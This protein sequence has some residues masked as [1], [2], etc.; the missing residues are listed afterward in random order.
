MN[1]EVARQ[2]PSYQILG[3]AAHPS[4]RDNLQ[5]F[6]RHNNEI[7]RLISDGKKVLATGKGYPK[8]A[9]RRFRRTG[10]GTYALYD[11]KRDVVVTL[12][13]EK[14]GAVLRFG[15]R[16]LRLGAQK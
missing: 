7:L 6:V 8:S 12:Q 14:D 2:N 9:Q 16:E 4:S 5:T 15:E 3:T 11:A 13:V 1:A 10:R